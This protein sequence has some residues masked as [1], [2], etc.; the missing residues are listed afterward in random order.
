MRH[1]THRRRADHRAPLVAFVLLAVAV[2]SPSRADDAPAR[3]TP[4]NQTRTFRMG[5]ETRS[6]IVHVPPRFDPA[7]PTPV[8]LVYHGAGANAALMILFCGMNETADRHNFVV[9]YPNGTGQGGLF[10]VWNAGGYQGPGADKLPDDVAYTA[11]LLDDLATVV[12]VDPRR[13]YA[14]G[15]SNGGMMCYLLASKMS[16]RIAAIAPVAGTSCVERIE[17]TRPVPVMHFH[18][19]ADKIL[20]YSGYGP[21]LPKFLK[22]T[23]VDDTISAWAAHDGCPQKPR[24]FAEPNTVADETSVERREYRPGKNG[25]EVV[26]YVIEGG[27]HTWPGKPSPLGWLGKSTADISANDLIWDFFQ[28]HPLR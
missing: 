4:G 16:D 27:G 14:A 25:S 8:V 20:P 21:E 5:D 9:V 26:L 3:L 2:A 24:I 28:K 6:Y 23:S 10:L 12:R 18:G 1:H 13:V 22:F 11:R 15:M 19:T 17:S 7:K